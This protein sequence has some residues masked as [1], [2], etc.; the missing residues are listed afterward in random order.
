[1]SPPLALRGFLLSHVVQATT[2]GGARRLRRTAN[3]CWAACRRLGPLV[4]AVVGLVDRLVAGEA[5]NRSG[6]S[7]SSL[8]LLEA[9]VASSTLSWSPVV[10]V[11]VASPSEVPV[12]WDG[13]EAV[14]APGRGWWC[15]PVLLERAVTHWLVSPS[16]LVVLAVLPGKPLLLCSDATVHQ[17]AER[18]ELASGHQLENHVV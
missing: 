17:V 4:G 11:L 1:M 18:G 9:V 8:P 10:V 2:V 14:V 5:N 12:W 6:T 16:L 13:A 7:V 15:T 3:G